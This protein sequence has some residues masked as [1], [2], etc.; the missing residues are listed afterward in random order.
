MTVGRP[1]HPQKDEI[2]AWMAE[3]GRGYS[4]ASRE[5]GVSAN[6]IKTWVAAERAKAK[7]AEASPAR[8]RASARAPPRRRARGGP[9]DAVEAALS[10]VTGTASSMGRVE[11]YASRLDALAAATADAVDR[12]H[13]GTA[14]E[15][16]KVALTTRKELDLARKEEGAEAERKR[17]AEIR[18]PTTLARSLL[19]KLPQLLEV[20]EDL[21]LAKAARLTISDWIAS[22][23]R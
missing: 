13:G 16:E 15:L 10:K 21:A 8:P 3:T 7:A 1:P 11:Y 5:F 19:T 20:A 4:K 6:T 18:D 14:K 22:R 17:R 23:E 12:G 2:I 9:K